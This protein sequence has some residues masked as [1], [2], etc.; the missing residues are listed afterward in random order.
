MANK[1]L[2]FD[3][4]VQIFKDLQQNTIDARLAPFVIIQDTETEAY[5]DYKGKVIDPSI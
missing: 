2:Q 1:A 3:E 5:F 4:T